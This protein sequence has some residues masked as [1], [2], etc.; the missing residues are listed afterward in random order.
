MSG[1]KPAELVQMTIVTL[2][3]QV[4]RISLCVFPSISL[5]KTHVPLIYTNYFLL[6]VDRLEGIINIKSQCSHT[7]QVK[8][9][10]QSSYCVNHSALLTHVNRDVGW[11]YYLV[12]LDLSKT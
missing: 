12:Y 4:Q 5:S 6:Y 9:I 1:G 10:V 3:S 11:S 8:F 2:C 7:F